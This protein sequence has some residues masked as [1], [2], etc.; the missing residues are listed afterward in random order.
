MTTTE[1]CPM[2]SIG[3]RFKPLSQEQLE[4]PYSF[5]AE[6][7]REEPVF[8]SPAFNMWVVTRYSD[9]R[10]VLGKPTM[11]SSRR[12]I[13]PIVEIAPEAYA[14]LAS[15][16][17][18]IPVLVNSDPPDHAR[19]RKVLNRAFSPPR[20]RLLEPEIREITQAQIDAVE[21]LGRTDAMQTLAFPI[22]VRV[23]ARLLDVEDEHADQLGRWGRSLIALVSSALDPEQ[24]V[25]AATDVVHLQR[26]MADLL[27]R[28]RTEPGDDI[29][30]QMLAA[31]EEPFTDDELVFQ[32]TGLLI[33]GHETTAYMIG[34]AI[35]LLLQKP[36]HWKAVVADPAL[37][38]DAIEETLRADTSV[39]AFIRTAT[40]D[41]ELAGRNIAKGENVLVVFASAN[42]DE[43]H[44]THPESFDPHRTSTVG[45]MGF[46]HGIH[47][48]VGA[49]LARLEGRV[50]LETLASRLPDLRLVPDQPLRHFPQLIFRGFER[51]DVAWD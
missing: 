31:G 46:G 36:E 28:K 47:S 21:P 14:V 51:L 30:S 25:A 20:M 26:F 16:P 15:G 10:A 45:H 17:P 4:D 12:T 32:M 50:V 3:E 48:C 8:Y 5:Y 29:A 39:P 35:Q 44:F 49:G 23:I 41:I 13:D 34:N 24:Q 42:H 22:P 37:I 6:A 9:A 38:P 43:D 2:S 27:Q 7:R 33:A 11:F 18:V 19:F 40:T 1:S